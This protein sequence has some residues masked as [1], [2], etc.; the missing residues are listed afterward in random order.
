MFEIKM[1]I[2][3]FSHFD[4]SSSEFIPSWHFRSNTKININCLRRS[5]RVGIHIKIYR[6]YIPEIVIVVK[7][8][9]RFKRSHVV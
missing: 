6:S 4:S 3:D 1:P 9:C 5:F 8:C 2:G 7:Y